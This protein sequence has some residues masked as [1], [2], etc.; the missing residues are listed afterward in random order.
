M[1]DNEF[2]VAG[3]SWMIGPDK[4]LPQTASDIQRTALRAISANKK[5]IIVFTD[6]EL[7][8][9]F[10]EKLGQ[11]GIGQ[12]PFSS[13]SLADFAI[14]LSELAAMGETH[15]AFDPGAK[16]ARFISISRILAGISKQLGQSQ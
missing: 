14:E 7:A 9:S 11:A 3:R 13:T 4:A 10:I 8:E 16:S 12:K 1:D 2:F 6:L 15:I 5:S